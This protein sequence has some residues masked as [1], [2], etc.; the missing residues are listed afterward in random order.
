MSNQAEDKAWKQKWEHLVELAAELNLADM[1]QG[2]PDTD[3]ICIFAKLAQLEQ[4]LDQLVVDIIVR[5]AKGNELSVEALKQ[6][7]LSDT[8]HSGLDDDDDDDDDDETPNLKAEVDRI[9]VK[10][11]APND[12][13]ITYI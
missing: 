12:D 1:A 11:K 10:P 7:V 4:R 2:N 6:A 9:P 5:L 3:K 8:E 13:I